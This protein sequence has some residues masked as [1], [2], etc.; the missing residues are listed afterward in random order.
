MINN[1][2]YTTSLF[3]SEYY[4]IDNEPYSK[5]RTQ[6]AT[7]EKTLKVQ[8][9]DKPNECQGVEISSPLG[10]TQVFRPEELISA[11]GKAY[12]V[13]Y[14]QAFIY[15]TKKCEGSQIIISYNGEGYSSVGDGRIFTALNS[16]GEVTETLH[17]VLKGGKEQLDYLNTIKD[18]VEVIDDVKITTENG[19]N[20]MKIIE[21]DIVVADVLDK[22]LKKSTV[23]GNDCYA[24]LDPTVT[25][26]KD[27]Y[28]KLQST[29][30]IANTTYQQLKATNDTATARDTHLQA[31]IDSAKNIDEKI[32]S[33]KH[34]FLVITPENWG[35]ARS[36][37]D[38]TYVWRHGLKSEALTVN[39]EK[40]VDGKYNSVI[41]EYRRI[42]E[43]TM[44]VRSDTNEQIQIIASAS[45]YGGTVQDASLL[46]VDEMNNG[47]VNQF[48]TPQV[49]QE[50]I[51]IHND[52]SN[53]AVKVDKKAE[54]QYLDEELSK[55]PNAVDVYIKSVVDG[56]LAQKRDKA[57]LI[58]YPDL[59]N[60]V[61]LGMTGGSVPVVGPGSVGNVE[62]KNNEITQNKIQN[63][64][65]GRLKQIGSI[66]EILTKNS[67]EI[68][69][70]EGLLKIKNAPYIYTDTT[71]VKFG[72]DNTTFPIDKVTVLSKP[73][74]LYADLVTL[75]VEFAPITTITNPYII[76]C[77]VFF[78][79]NIN[80]I[81][82]N[83]CGNHKS[84]K[85]ID[86]LG[87]E[88]LFEEHSDCATGFI[89]PTVGKQLDISKVTG[90]ITDIKV[91]GTQGAMILASNYRMSFTNSYEQVITLPRNN[92]LSKLYYNTQTSLFE[93]YNYNVNI[94]PKTY[95]I[96]ISWFMLRDT[97]GD[98]WGLNNK[99]IY[100]NGKVSGQKT[101][102]NG[103]ICNCLGDSITYGLKGSGRL[104]RPYP[105][106]LVE[107]CGFDTVNNCG[108]SSS[109]I[110]T[111]TS[112][113]NW[114]EVRN[115]MV[116]RYVNMPDADVITV[117][118]GVNDYIVNV[119]KGDINSRDTDTFY[120]ALH[121]L[122]SGLIKKYPDKTILILIPL[123]IGKIHRDKR[124]IDS[125]TF[126]QW[127]EIIKEMCRYYCLPYEDLYNTMGVNPDM[128]EQ[129]YLMPDLLHLSQQLTDRVARRAGKSINYRL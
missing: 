117:L 73:Y 84:I 70:Q 119:P 18:A 63:N 115:P 100:L 16:S 36:V 53:V 62:L 10:F 37:G 91:T 68:N 40:L 108:I 29:N 33:T 104:D 77:Y 90:S 12:Y 3:N 89:Y 82:V 24:K 95:L 8:L 13:A 78:T 32:E 34:K 75:T 121:E 80:N 19:R 106:Q 5:V 58:D 41:P 69:I 6:I 96:F 72:I 86:N 4:T 47:I 2:D 87:I 129:Q 15:F 92:Y 1:N 71:S 67:I 35:N 125:T 51:G 9:E 114:N 97:D 83:F 20:V 17:E 43:N 88:I 128:A 107:I 25:S 127:C 93:A 123:R 81:T 22:N 103:S 76:L 124:T 31:T 110:A 45:Y 39:I 120:G 38:Y 50:I 122:F 118:G 65:V 64:Q 59:T 52:I 126:E 112:V 56:Y 26:A 28:P 94:P 42:D 48:V 101:N 57:A 109:T 7:I 44:E 49:R 85:V 98:C 30:E 11:K 46:N 61:K 27:I 105:S 99:S 23:D 113:S 55:K 54:K 66:G 14:E 116:L 21:T 111:N 79:S 74:V 60:A 102:P